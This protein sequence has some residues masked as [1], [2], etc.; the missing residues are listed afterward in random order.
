M[1]HHTIMDPNYLDPKEKRDKKL[2]ELGLFSKNIPKT[3]SRSQM[4]ADKNSKYPPPKQLGNLNQSNILFDILFGG[5]VIS[6]GF[7]LIKNPNI[8]RRI[9]NKGNDLASSSI[10]KFATK[11]ADDALVINSLGD[12]KK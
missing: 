4:I 6:Q 5:P 2:T 8:V 7:K 1:A 9:I 3:P 11:H 10:G 12:T